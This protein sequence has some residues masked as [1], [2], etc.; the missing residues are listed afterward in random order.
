MRSITA[1]GAF[2]VLA[3]CAFCGVHEAQAQ[4]GVACAGVLKNDCLPQT[5]T[6]MGLEPKPLGEGYLIL[7]ERDGWKLYVDLII[8]SDNTKVGFNSNL[9]DVNEQKVSAAQWMGLLA[10]NKDID[11]SV[12]FYDAAKKKLYIHRVLDNRSM[13]PAILREQLDRFLADIRN[14]EKIWSPVTQ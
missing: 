10:S 2:A 11:P 13:T 4:A 1:A 8:S 6:D 9:G 3:L 14:S 5:L 7:I 12:F